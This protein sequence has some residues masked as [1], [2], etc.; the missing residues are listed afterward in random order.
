MIYN[1]YKNRN[2]SWERY[3]KY[4]FEKLNNSTNSNYI[5]SFN[6]KK[7]NDY[8]GEKF[9]RPIYVLVDTE[10]GSSGES[11]MQALRQMSNVKVI[12]QNTMGSTH[13]GNQGLLILPSSRIQISMSTKFIKFQNGQF[14]EKIGH[15]PDIYVPDGKDALDYAINQIK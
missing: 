1:S 15:Q 7:F 11:T 9:V 3:K 4:Y 5:S 8:L 13:F 6:N 14:V 2:G 12:G 10:C